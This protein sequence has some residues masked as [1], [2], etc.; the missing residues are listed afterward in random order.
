MPSQRMA[1]LKEERAA[2]KAR[3]AA[4]AANQ[5]AGPP[6]PF[7]EDVDDEDD[8]S[9]HQPGRRGRRAVSRQPGDQTQSTSNAAGKKTDAVPDR[10]VTDPPQGSSDVQPGKISAPGESLVA[11]D[12][13][14]GLGNSAAQATQSPAPTNITFDLTGDDDDDEEPGKSLHLLFIDRAS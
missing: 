14:A 10:T 4:F 9:I 11:S 2:K 12:A 3:T 6:R 13:Y 8:E 5:L 7:V 1:E